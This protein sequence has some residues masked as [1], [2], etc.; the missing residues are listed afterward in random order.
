MAFNLK[1][2]DDLPLSATN[3]RPGESHSFP[4]DPTDADANARLAL[5]ADRLHELDRYAEWDDERTIDA[6]EMALSGLGD[7]VRLEADARFPDRLQ[8]ERPDIVFNVAEGRGGV[9]RESYVPTFCEFWD[10]PYT[11]S[12][13]LAL[14][15]CLDKSR[16]K[17]VL[18][19]YGVSTPDFVLARGR[20]ELNGRPSLPVIV[21]PVHEG[22]S[23]GISQSSVCGRRSQVVEAVDRIVKT[24]DQPALVERFLPGRE[25]TVAILGNGHEARA[26]PLVEIDHAVLP[27][28]SRSIYGYEAK[29]IWDRPE[30]PLEI[31]RC[32]ADCDERLGRR[33][34][35]IALTG[36]RVLGCRD[37]ARVD[38][39]CD[40]S[41]EP[42][43]LEV[44]PLPGV[45][46]DPEANS[47]FPKAARAAGLSYADLIQAVL[48]AAASRYELAIPA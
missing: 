36:Y 25:F 32:P 20:A 6:L 15:I 19:Y 41:G 30:A 5:S 44:N 39:R 46:P 21:K 43:I 24:Y 45:L 13:P 11:G 2:T 10:I 16:A 42:H 29:W 31:F 33:V 38:V 40:A 9:S 22:S 47:C 18:S 4:T 17:E 14:G 26:L 37:W 28:H 27:V 3:A 8:Q 1:P 48:R 7:V 34:R 35:E 23:K 12:D